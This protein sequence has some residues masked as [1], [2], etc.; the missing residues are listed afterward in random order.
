MIKNLINL[1]VDEQ[2]TGTQNKLVR[3]LNI[4]CLTWYLAITIF[5]I[6]D[7]FFEEQYL[8]T[9]AGHLFQFFFL[10]IVQ[11]SQSKKKYTL[12][13]SLFIGISF[14]QMFTFCNL[15]LPGRLIEFYYIM[16]PLFSLLFLKKWVYHIFF[17]LLIIISF[18]IPAY[19][20][21][22][23]DVNSFNT[24]NLPIVF[25]VV[26][27]LVYYF[28]DVN[29]RNEK[30]LELQKNNAL[31]DKEII[32]QQK[33]EMEKLQEV[34]NN[35]F[36]NVAHEI[37]TPLTILT[38]NT[39]MIFS[40]I[41][42]PSTTQKDEI[43][44]VE[45]QHT[46]IQN[47]INDVIDLS[48]MD[49]SDFDFKKETV[50]LDEIILKALSSHELLFNEKSIQLLFSSDHQGEHHINGSPIFLERVINN[51]LSNA[52]KYAPSHSEVKIKLTENKED[53]VLTISDSGT[54]IAEADTK[55]IFERFY[56]SNHKVNASGGNGV[57]LAFC[58]EIIEKHGGTIMSENL[59][60]GGACFTVSLP[61]DELGTEYLLD[62]DPII[63]LPDAAENTKILLVEDSIDMQKYLN[64]ILTDYKI[65]T[66]ANGIEALDKLKNESFDL[67][68]TDYMMPEMNG[69]ELITTL[70]KKKDKTPIIMLTARQGSETKLNILSLGIDD[71]I[72]K[73][74]DYQELIVRI[75]NCLKNNHHR[76]TFNETNDIAVSE[77]ENLSSLSAMKDFILKNCHS[78]TFNKAELCEQFALS[79]STL[80]RKIKSSSGLSPKEFIN[81]V[82]L[83]EAERLLN[84]Y[85]TI[86]LKELAL[87]LGYV[88]Y[89]YFGKLYEKRFGKSVS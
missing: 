63:D 71:F 55:K 32:A 64:K 48:R 74:F 51:L 76:N 41:D 3:L 22:T 11:Y 38:G 24:S 65:T 57:G 43:K 58:K 52:Y 36:I 66:V 6:T 40:S 33:K 80:Y 37:R 68:L 49:R 53:H 29:E 30:L 13:R 16:I 18:I 42:E 9:W 81:E 50:L 82:K 85:P 34:Q 77:D 72:T 1:G 87:Q 83:K 75:N 5:I 59:P 19:L 14:L 62:T 28:K 2:L 12:A 84:E 56:Q 45:K 86:G 21:D 7:Y 17:L 89:T 79:N 25:S 4:F 67:I 20:F 46:K 44:E 27:L 23:Y 73:P 47:I 10:M 54:G 78:V 35:F 8:F 31:H 69:Y 61:K 88:N 60:E 39:K 15:I 70:K 26:F